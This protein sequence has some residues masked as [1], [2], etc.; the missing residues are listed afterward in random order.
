MRTDELCADCGGFD[1]EWMYHCQKHG[2]VPHC[3]GCSCPYCDEEYVDEPPD[4][5]ETTVE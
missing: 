1:V 3:R 4:F 2:G 5:D